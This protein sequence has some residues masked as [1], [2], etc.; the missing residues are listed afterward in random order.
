MLHEHPHDGIEGERVHSDVVDVNPNYELLFVTTAVLFIELLVFHGE[1]GQCD[2]A[3]CV[4][5]HRKHSPLVALYC[6]KKCFFGRA[7]IIHQLAI[8]PI[9]PNHGNRGLSL[10][11][12]TQKLLFFLAKI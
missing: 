6:L 11:F 5:Q 2:E 8:A 4:N 9:H 10:L 7:K 3:Y 1:D 12:G